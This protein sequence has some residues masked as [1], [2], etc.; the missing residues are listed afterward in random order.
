MRG[1]HVDRARRDE[2]GCCKRGQRG[3]GRRAPRGRTPTRTTCGN[4][5]ENRKPHDS[6]SGPATMTRPGTVPK[7]P[8][9][10]NRPSASDAIG[11]DAEAVAHEVGSADQIDALAAE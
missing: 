7:H 6:N 11:G 5:G 4:D 1:E 8:M 2:A 10:T 9:I 3:L